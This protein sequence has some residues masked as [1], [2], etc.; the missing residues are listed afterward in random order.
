MKIA[1]DC[2]NIAKKI[3]EIINEELL[4]PQ[5]I[6]L[7]ERYDV[8]PHSLFE[9]TKGYLE[10][11]NHQINKCYKE[12]CYDACAVMIRRLVEALIIEVFESHRISHKIKNGKG[13]FLYLDELINKTL[14]ETSWNLSRNTKTALQRK[15]FKK[16]GDQSAHS[17]HYNAR[18]RYIDDIINDLRAVSEDL[19]YLANLKK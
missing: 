11:I 1:K 6:T 18:R 17:R 19:L 5:E 12:A 2:L 13:E 7:S 15:Y 3:K 8:L 16:I 4:P 14:A 10:K 9:N